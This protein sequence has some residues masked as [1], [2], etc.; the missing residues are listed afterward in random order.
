MRPGRVR[1]AILALVIMTLFAAIG[2]RMQNMLIAGNQDY[3]AQ[4]ESKKTKT[5]TLTGMRGKVLDRN[6]IPLAYDRSSFNVQFYRDPSKKS[7]D[8]RA[9]YTQAILS[10]IR[11]VEGNG[12]STIDGFW[13]KK[14]P[15]TGE[16][17]FDTGTDDE[18]VAAARIKSW[19]GN[20]MVASESRYPVQSLFKTLCDNYR[21]PDDLSEEDKIKVLAIWQEQRMN[22]F[23]SRPVTIAYDV[24]FETVSEIEVRANEL[25]G[26]SIVGGSERV[27]PKGSLAAH[28]VGYISRISGSET[29]EDYLAKGYSRDALVGMT[30]IEASMEDQLTPYIEYRQGKQVVEI[31]SVGKIIR[32]ISFEQPVSGNSVVLTL[33][34]QL[35]AI[36]ETAL[37]SNID[38]IRK[39]QEE[40]IASSKWR[41]ANAETLAEYEAAGKQ[42]ATAQTGALVAMDPNSGAVL[43]MVSEPGFDLG[44]FSGQIDQ[45]AWNAL[46]TDPRNPMYNRAIQARDTPGSIFKMVTALGGLMEG[47]LTLDERISDEGPFTFTD[48]ANPPSCWIAPSLRWTHAEQNVQEGLAHSCNYFFFTVGNRLGSTLLTKWAAQL[49]LTSRTGIELNGESTSFVGN[50]DK[51]YDAGRAIN[52]QYTSKPLFIAATIKSALKRIG[53]DRQIQYDDDRLDRVT[54]KLLDLV[55]VERT[56]DAWIPL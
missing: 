28:T 46:I 56:K 52:S 45:A 23:L 34:S 31:N 20:F 1:L 6:M 22:N 8:D 16:W 15:E 33:D 4:A 14:N 47:K 29:L 48:V 11:I 43:A 18:Q 19:R 3:V 35:Q 5:I 54:K 38:K 12:R 13:L 55:I 39:V 36:A 53:Q 49:G 2:I 10:V 41:K 37:R 26:V 50:Q 9:A 27:Y 51:L 25:P 21:V 40:L 44:I 7:D 24:G 17:Y 42:V 30:G 32:Q